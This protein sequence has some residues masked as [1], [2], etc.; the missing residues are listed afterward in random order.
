MAV[1]ARRAAM[2]LGAC[3]LERSEGEQMGEGERALARSPHLREPEVTSG[4]VNEA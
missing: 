1:E 2:A 3:A 4:G